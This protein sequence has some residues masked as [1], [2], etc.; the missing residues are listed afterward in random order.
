MP[1]WL[2]SGIAVLL[3]SACHGDLPEEPPAVGRAYRM[4]F[5]AIPPK[6]DPAVLVQALELSARRAVGVGRDL[7]DFLFVQALGLSSYPYFAYPDPEQIPLDYY[8]R[9]PGGRSLSLLVVEGGWP[10]AS[11]GSIVTSPGEQARYLAHQGRLL[12]AANV[13]FVSQLFA[14][15]LAR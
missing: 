7:Q 3:L 13:V 15:P 1:L 11:V 5:S 10:S 14:R 6:P 12:D 8:A 2:A 9:L 4:G